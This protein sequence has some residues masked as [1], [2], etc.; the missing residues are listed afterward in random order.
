MK[1]DIRRSLRLYVTGLVMGIADLIP[2]VSGG[3]IAF[4]SG[5]YEELLVSIKLV[6]G[7]VPKLFFQGH[8]RKGWSLIPFRF[9]LSLGAGILT[10][11][12]LLASTFS[13]FLKT[14]PTF[15]WAFFFGLVLAS[16]ALVLKRIR[17]WR[18]FYSFGFFLAALFAYVLVGMV[19]VETSAALWFIFV[20]GML[21]ISAM[22]L[23]GISGS[24]I[25]LLLG[26]YEQILDAVID[27]NVGLLAV[28]FLG[29]LFGLALFARFLSWLFSRHH[30]ISVALLAGF[31]L[32]SLRKI[33][34]W[35]I[36]VQ[37]GFDRHGVLVSIREI[38]TFPASFDQSFFVAL[39]LFLL[40]IVL[41]WYLHHTRLL[42]E[43]RDDL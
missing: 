35:K 10:A 3:T 42:K 33:W 38:N 32:G 12:I 27:H 34:P 21:A 16:I 20:S 8:F 7:E 43:R 25:L 30:D 15:V 24:F 41:V 13:F 14:Y 19:P 4:I 26:K 6:T 9:L 18:S 2:G 31:M 17:R 29:A 36:T 5:I 1:P 39:L 40:G 28:F 23:P 22:I 11:I 37:T